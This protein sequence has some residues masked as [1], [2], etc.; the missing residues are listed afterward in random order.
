M[1]NIINKFN[2]I[3]K[4]KDIDINKILNNQQKEI[5]NHEENTENYENS[6]NTGNTKNTEST[7]NFDI[8]TLLKFKNI[9]DKINN[10]NNPRN[11]LLSSLKPF[12]RNDKKEKLE[13]YTKIANIIYIINTLNEDKG[14][15]NC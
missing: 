5:S 3:L 4:N 12:L 7:I 9:F 14:D 15:D 13:Q 2:N 8:A 11:N 10:T 6:K 1:S